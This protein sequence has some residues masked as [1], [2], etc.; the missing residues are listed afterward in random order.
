MAH[1]KKLRI[2]IT[3][4][5]AIFMFGLWTGTFAA[6]VRDGNDLY[7]KGKKL[8]D[9]SDFQ[10]ATGKWKQALRIFEVHNYKEGISQTLSMLGF[11]YFRA[12]QY[13]KALSCR[14]KELA[15][16]KQ[17][18]DKEREGNATWSIGNIY[19]SLGQHEQALTYF[20]KALAI[21]KDIGDRK[22]EG[23]VL[24]N[25][26]EEHTKLE[27]YQKAF[28]YYEKALVIHREIGNRID[29]GFVLGQSCYILALLG[30]RDKALSYHRKALDIY[31]EVN[32]KKGEGEILQ[33]GFSMYIALDQHEK[34]I[35]CLKEASVIH[36]EIGDREREASDLADIGAVC[37]YILDQHDKAVGYFKKALAIHR[38]IGNKKG[39]SNSLS[40]IGE[41]FFDIGLYG[42]AFAYHEK[43]LAI[44][45]GIGDKEGEGNDLE[46]IGANCAVL[47]W[48]EKAI[49]YYE[50]ALSIHRE[51]GNKK[52]E[53]SVLWFMGTV[54]LD[55]G[56]SEKAIGCYEKALAI[57]REIGDKYG[58]RGGLL[59]IRDAYLNLGR[60]EKALDYHEEMKRKYKPHTFMVVRNYDENEDAGIGDMYFE[61]GQIDEAAKIY[62]ETK[63]KFRLGRLYL[64]KKDFVKSLEYFEALLNEELKRRT[65][66][67][68]FKAL[69]GLGL[70]YE[71]MKE[72]HKAKK[73]YAEAIEIVEEIRTSLT[74]ARR[75][76]FFAG[77]M[78]GDFPRLAPYEGLIRVLNILN[79][80][81]AALHY[82]EY[83]KAR[84][85]AEA[86]AS[87][88]QSI[89]FHL[90]AMLATEEKSLVNQ[91]AALY[92]KREKAYL[93]N[94]IYAYDNIDKLLKAKKHEQQIIISSIRKD[95]P[96]YASIK[97]PQP[98]K[99]SEIPLKKNEY[100]V[101][102][103]VTDDVT[104]ACVLHK[105]KIVNSV[106]IPVSRKDLTK[107]VKEYRSFF[108]VSRKSDL[109]QFDPKTGHKLYT[110][111]LKE[112]IASVHK[113]RHIIIVPD[114]ILGVL[115]FC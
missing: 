31:S 10:G 34:A 26:G 72:Y 32:D 82:A 68:T 83:T 41:V 94:R 20:E 53:A 21:Y 79:Q 112:I 46:G 55:L 114:E 40:H 19:S 52:G 110:L 16:N 22:W 75:S 1:R 108:Q 51:I 43:A 33:I 57:H 85:F 71:G 30:K 35:T 50:K 102:Y 62:R 89:T 13:E 27:H 92:K 70:S 86:I 88:H 63:D 28:S 25:I 29:E 111:L 67:A 109:A 18:G 93:E 78:L 73:Y 100:L 15:I 104:I 6:S 74:P 99:A 58:E 77:K 64:A 54:C 44:H 97:Y 65:P 90:P 9:Q 49:G 12:G 80:H 23:H 84:L 24:A 14:E 61:R 96:E 37:G 17:L 87:K 113:D 7:T 107:L 59:A 5:I 105:G 101:E 48:H 11:V 98:L 3:L 45:R 4:I 91:I 56:L 69:V 60:Y 103:E 42:K 39:E 2:L 76:N 95:Y 8:Y 47:G 66:S 115:P 106:T 81:E 38:E 36:K